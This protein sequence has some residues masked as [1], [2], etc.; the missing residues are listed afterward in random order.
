MKNIFDLSFNRRDLITKVLPSCAVA[1]LMPG[2]V[3]KSYGSS[4]IPAVFQEEIHKFDKE[5][6]FNKP[7]TKKQYFGVRHMKYIQ[8]AKS[9]VEDLGEDKALD[10]IKSYTRKRMFAIGKQGAER[11]G[12]NSFKSYIDIFRKP[13]MLDTLTLEVVEDT[14]TVYELKITECLSH[15]I[16]KILK[17]DGKFGFASVCYGD[18]AWAEGW[19]PKIKLVRDKTLM[20][21]HDCCNHRYIWTG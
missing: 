18:Y 14:D 7:L 11:A 3:S 1:G 16:Y 15:V 9:L 20:E 4:G 10:L 19:N 8:F 2:L 6:K 21:G 13:D 5:Y 17:F 12:N